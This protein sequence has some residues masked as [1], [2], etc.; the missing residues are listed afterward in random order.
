[1]NWLAF[2]LIAWI[3]VGLEV[4]LKSA[5]ALG[6]T[7]IAP[8]F[9]VPYATFVALCAQPRQAFW[10]C[11]VLGLMIDLT[12]V[13]SLRNGDVITVMGPY[14]LGL[15]L[16]GQLVLTMRGIMMR[17]NPLTLVVLAVLA[18]IIMHVI[19]VAIMTTRSLFGDPIVWDP[20]EQIVERLGAS[21]YTGVAAGLMSLVLF[22][23]AP[24]LGFAAGR[25]R[26]SRP[27][28]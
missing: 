9:V 3:V 16:G 5:L 25:H 8:S 20:M 11:L 26:I 17:Q 13:T 19:V 12:S 21:L 15:I 7:A 14:A 10:A 1:V 24:V 2:A 23:M 28:A 4:G 22:P 18:S 6:N 27:S